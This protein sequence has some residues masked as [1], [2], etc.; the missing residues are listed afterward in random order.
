MSRRKRQQAAL[1]LTAIGM[2]RHVADRLIAAVGL[3]EVECKLVAL[4][5]SWQ[6][7]A[8]A[9]VRDEANRHTIQR[10]AA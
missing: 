3:P 9:W 2:P 10:R 4:G 1:T 8:R 5:W 7:A 6:P